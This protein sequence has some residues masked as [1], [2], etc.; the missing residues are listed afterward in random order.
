VEKVPDELL[1]EGLQQ[2]FIRDWLDDVTSAQHLFSAL[3]VPPIANAVEVP[4]AKPIIGVVWPDKNL[5]IMVNIPVFK[6]INQWRI[7]QS[8]VQ[9]LS[10]RCSTCSYNYG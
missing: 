8:C 5:G 9:K 10:S 6:S 2:I 4:H 3:V 7:K 1:P